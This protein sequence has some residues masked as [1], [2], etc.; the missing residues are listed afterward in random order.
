MPKPIIPSYPQTKRHG[1]KKCIFIF[2][3]MVKIDLIIYLSS[4]CRISLITLTPSG[5]D[6]VSAKKSD[7]A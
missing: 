1:I 6:T 7:T 3:S 4:A 2:P 5:I